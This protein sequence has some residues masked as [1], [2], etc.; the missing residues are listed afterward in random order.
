MIKLIISLLLL[1]SS[2]FAGDLEDLMDDIGHE[3]SFGVG[4]GMHHSRNDYVGD[5]FIADGLDDF[6]A[7]NFYQLSLSAFLGSRDLQMRVLTFAH[8]SNGVQTSNGSV[9]SNHFPFWELNGNIGIA[10][11]IF[12]KIYIP[13]FSIMGSF[14]YYWFYGDARIDPGFY[15][16][17]YWNFHL[18]EGTDWGIEVFNNLIFDKMN[19]SAESYN[20][21]GNGGD[22][23]FRVYVNFIGKLVKDSELNGGNSS[24]YQPDY[25]TTDYEEETEDEPT[26]D[27]TDIEPTENITDTTSTEDETT[28][29]ETSIEQ[30]EN[31]TENKSDIEASNDNSD[32][33]TE[34]EPTNSE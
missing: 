1:T 8:Y 22:Y 27:S 9:I 33:A 34:D 16:S 14:N 11:D 19:S 17:A 23:G 5:H 3:A 20:K 26:E 21:V 6:N 28:T 13:A 29:D 25:T 4:L 30:N 12:D 2:I 18:N 24:E 15:T 31:E 7:M 32:M 10:V